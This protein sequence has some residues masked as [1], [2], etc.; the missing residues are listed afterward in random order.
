[1]NDRTVKPAIEP[2]FDFAWERGNEAAAQEGQD[3]LRLLRLENGWT[4]DDVH[5]LTDYAVPPPRQE[6]LEDFQAW[7][8]FD[9]IVA[10]ARIYGMTPGGLT[11]KMLIESDPRRQEARRIVDELKDRVKHSEEKTTPEVVRGVAELMGLEVISAQ[12]DADEVAVVVRFSREDVA[13]TE[14]QIP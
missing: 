2:N 5:E 10:L 3:V 1:M 8:D 4:W 14:V 12:W 11:D 13:P 7:P 9:E 6:L